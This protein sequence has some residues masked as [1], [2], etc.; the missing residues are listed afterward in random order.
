MS[1]GSV[2][3]IVWAPGCQ[4]SLAAF[5]GWVRDNCLRVVKAFVLFAFLVAVC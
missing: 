2:K 3:F 4:V 1:Y 5:F